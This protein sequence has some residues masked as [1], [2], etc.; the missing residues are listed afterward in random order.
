ME[1]LLIITS[2]VL[3]A[4]GAT[5][6][7]AFSLRKQRDAA[8]RDVAAIALRLSEVEKKM[9]QGQGTSRKEEKTKPAIPQENP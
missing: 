9:E 1:L 7:I 8:M 5:L 6:T 2:V 4:L 3:V